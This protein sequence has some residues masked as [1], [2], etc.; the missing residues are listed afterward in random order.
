LKRGH[1]L[2]QPTISR[3]LHG[4]IQYPSTPV[5]KGLADIF[6][7]SE[8]EIRGEPQ[9]NQELTP[10]QRSIAERWAKLPS[11]VQ[12]FLASQIDQILDFQDASP[13]AAEKMFKGLP[14][15]RK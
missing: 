4:Q 11:P 15:S 13:K 2:S 8:T 6:G 10:L 12:D 1:S 9:K 14:K 7:V 5:V 3:I